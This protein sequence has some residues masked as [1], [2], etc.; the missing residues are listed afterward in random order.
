[1]AV[2]SS[3]L[4]RR[5]TI[6]ARR[7][8][9]TVV[10]RRAA[11][12]RR[13]RRVAATKQASCG[14][15]RSDSR[16]SRRPTACSTGRRR[17]ARRPYVAPR[18]DRIRSGP[19][20]SDSSG[21][22]EDLQS[23]RLL[24]APALRGSGRS[25]RFWPRTG[26]RS[27]P[28]RRSLLVEGGADRARLSHGCRSGIVI[29]PR[30]AQRASAPGVNFSILGPSRNPEGRRG[31][32]ALR[33]PHVPAATR[34]RPIEASRR[35]MK[36]QQVVERDRE[37]DG[38]KERR[39]RLAPPV[40]S[41]QDAEVVERDLEPKRDLHELG[42]ADHVVLVA[43]ERLEPPREPDRELAV[44]PRQRLVH[45]GR[46]RISPRRERPMR[47]HALRDGERRPVESRAVER[48]DEARPRRRPRA[49]PSPGD[50]ASRGTGAPSARARSSATRVAPSMSSSRPAGKAVHERLRTARP[51]LPPGERQQP[52]V[53]DDPD[54]RRRRREA[55]SPRPSSRVR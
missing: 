5:R 21:S 26:R 48:V 31:G 44:V 18:G 2:R 16:S 34:A 40:R 49:Q 20:R 12:G 47:L 46:R 35:A 53:P 23:D 25:S 39:A 50:L 9:T 8:R 17:R 52:L 10:P 13:G 7:V 30:R 54:A 4:A 3:R 55:G 24:A 22:D 37:R 41:R 42:V 11:G 51:S 28:G 1:M 43:V 27:G 15:R 32:P 14:G 36:L 38:R 6:A 19:A 45:R 29:S 33:R